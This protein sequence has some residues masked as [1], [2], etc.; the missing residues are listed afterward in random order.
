VLVNYL[1]P[2]HTLF[3][4]LLEPLPPPV[5]KRWELGLSDLDDTS[6]LHG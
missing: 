3:V 2:A 1:K 5:P 6:L 4:D